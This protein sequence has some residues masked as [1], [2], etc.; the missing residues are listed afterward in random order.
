MYGDKMPDGLVEKMREE[1]EAA[2]RRV[3][4][5]KGKQREGD[6]V[7]REEA[8]KYTGDRMDVD[9]EEEEEEE[10]GEDGGVAIGDGEEDVVLFR[11]RERGANV[12]RSGQQHGRR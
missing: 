4:V 2:R 10:E 5:G 8:K 12:A 11:S 7:K 6:H 1:D 3:Q 9:D